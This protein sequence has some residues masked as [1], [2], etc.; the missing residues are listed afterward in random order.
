MARLGDPIIG[1]L[2]A[3]VYSNTQRNTRTQV[4]REKQYFP[5]LSFGP[6]SVSFSPLPT[7]PYNLLHAH[8]S[9]SSYLFSPLPSLLSP[10]FSHCSP[11]SSNLTSQVSIFASFSF[12]TSTFTSRYCLPLSLKPLFPSSYLSA[13]VFA[14]TPLNTFPISVRITAFR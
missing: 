9:I 6:S 7:A 13:L 10:L 8:L 1:D 5:S 11:P 4:H 12:F 3:D 2:D 14:L